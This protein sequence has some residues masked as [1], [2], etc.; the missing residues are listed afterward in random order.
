[1][2]AAATSITVGTT[3]VSSGTTGYILY[4]NGGT[5]GDLVTTG[6]GNVVL[7]TSPSISGL[8]VTSSFTAT[9]LVTNSELTGYVYCNGT[10]PC[11]S[12]TTVPTSAL[13]GTVNATNINGASV[14]ASATVV[15]TNS[16]SQIVA[17]TGTISNNTSGMAN[18]AISLTGTTVNSVP[19][20]SASGV[21]SYVSPNTSTTPMSLTMT[22]TGSAGT[23]PVWSDLSSTYV[24]KTQTTVQTLAGPLAWVGGDTG[25]P[26]ETTLANLGGISSLLT[27]TQTMVGPLSSQS[28]VSSPTINATNQDGIYLFSTFGGDS[29][30]TLYVY[31]STYGQ[32]WSIISNPV[33]P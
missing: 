1:M 24:S 11:T 10:S 32:Q 26:A 3:T 31:G 14:P 2:T 29:D 13:S 19:Y 9:G 16:S 15:G 27:T 7:A 30:T 17:Q 28:S 23:T 12:S 5:L 21:T 6:T 18:T 25:T 8:T 4:D 22:G 20:Q 33:S